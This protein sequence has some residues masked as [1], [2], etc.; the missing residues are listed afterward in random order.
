MKFNS[1]F[2]LVL[3]AMV[4]NCTSKND[5]T[6]NDIKVDKAKPEYAI[7][8]HGGAGTITR[9]DMTR[10]KEAAYISALNAALDAGEGEKIP[11]FE[12]VIALFNGQIFCN[13]ELKAP[14]A[15]EHK[16]RYDRKLAA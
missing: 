10:E 2:A 15:D 9:A 6:T 7:V 4:F 16:H 13:I 5:Q 8:I 11:T 14:R 3:V 1:I 12:E